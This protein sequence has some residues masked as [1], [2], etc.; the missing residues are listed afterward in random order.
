VSRCVHCGEQAGRLRR[1]H[2]ACRERHDN[3]LA[4]FPNFFVKYLASPMPPDKFRALA[5]EI[6]AGAFIRGDEFKEVCAGGLKAMIETATTAGELKPDDNAH[7]ATL[8]ETFGI[9]LHAL[10]GAGERLIK[11]SLLRDLRDG[12]LPADI[13]LDGPVVLNL[14]RDEAVVWVFNQVACYSVARS[15]K[16]ATHSQHVGR[17]HLTMRMNGFKAVASASDTSAKV[18]PENAPE[19]RAAKRSSA[20]PDASSDERTQGLALD[21]TGD[22]VLTNRHLC[23]LSDSTVL[24]IPLRAIVAVVPHADGLRVMRDEASGKP[25]TF[26]VDDPSF[27]ATAI[28]LLNR[29]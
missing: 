14:E 19:T 22:L 4:Q 29:F 20:R 3:A 7:I 15:D 6:A 11:A 23:F 21:G 8:A 16:P 9:D 26:V 24:K 13:R 25:Q 18:P 10:K 2:A 27:A 5:E 28:A 17:S 1:E 12:R